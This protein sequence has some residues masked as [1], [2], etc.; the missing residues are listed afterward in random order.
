MFGG[1]KKTNKNSPILTHANPW[2]TLGICMCLHGFFMGIAWVQHGWGIPSVF[3]FR[4]PI[5]G[6]LLYVNGFYGVFL[7]FSWVCMGNFT[8]S[9][10]FASGDFALSVFSWKKR[11]K[12]AKNHQNNLRFIRVSSPK[13]IGNGS[14]PLSRDPKVVVSPQIIE[15]W[16]KEGS[17]PEN[18]NT[19]C[20][21][22]IHSVFPGSRGIPR[23]FPQTRGIPRVSKPRV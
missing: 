14:S 23:V 20:I 17:T 22:G 4:N 13:T 1:E 12:T 15:N 11:K 3:R 6:V 7:F 10:R 16:S 2:K 19:Q 9:A 21:P 18:R 8:A 5:P